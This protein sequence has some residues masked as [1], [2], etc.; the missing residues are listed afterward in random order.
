MNRSPWV[1]SFVTTQSAYQPVTS[2]SDPLAELVGALT[3][4]SKCAISPGSKHSG[5]VGCWD[6]TMFSPIQTGYR[7]IQDKQTHKIYELVSVL[8]KSNLNKVAGIDV[9]IYVTLHLCL[10]QHALLVI[11]LFNSM[12]PY[13]RWLLQT[14]FFGKTIWFRVNPYWTYLKV[15][16]GQPTLIQ[17][18][19]WHPMGDKWSCQHYLNQWWLTSETLIVLVLMVEYLCRERDEVVAP[20]DGLIVK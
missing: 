6:V 15:I 5:V 9:I 14:K 10:T 2:G 12:V 3:R 17:I 20:D 4:Y 11:T 16:E 19:V 18:T 13:Y 8:I 7:K 1:A